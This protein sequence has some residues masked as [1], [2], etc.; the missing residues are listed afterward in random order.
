MN[1]IKNLVFSGSGSK[2]FIHIG[3]VKYLV[4]NNLFKNVNTFIGTSGGAIVSLLPLLIMIL[5]H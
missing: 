1:D 5:I 4:E 3:F 2:I